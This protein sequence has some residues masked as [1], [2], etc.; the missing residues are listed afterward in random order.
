MFSAAA[1]PS[2]AE[3]STSGAT[4]RRCR[5][6]RGAR[7]KHP[8]CGIRR[9]DGPRRRNHRPLRHLRRRRSSIACKPDVVQPNALADT[10][11]R[12]TARN[13]RRS[14]NQSPVVSQRTRRACSCRLRPGRRSSNHGCSGSALCKNPSPPAPSQKAKRGS[15]KSRGLHTRW[16]P[17]AADCDDR[18]FRPERARAGGRRRWRAT[19]FEF[20]EP[21][22]MFRAVGAWLVSARAFGLDDMPVCG[23]C[24]KS[25]RL[26]LCAAVEGS[27]AR[28]QCADSYAGGFVGRL[29]PGGGQ[30]RRAPA[31][32][33]AGGPWATT[34][35][36]P[37]RN[38]VCEGAIRGTR[39]L[40][41][42]GCN[43]FMTADSE[44]ALSA[45]AE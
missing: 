38:M 16:R 31:S 20:L 44:G 25:L 33:G 17:R 28:R 13:M 7:R 9:T 37:G 23:D 6:H 30:R 12:P 41:D 11:Q 32:G 40:S 43:S 2:F 42:E 14:R 8:A 5:Q 26:E 19:G 39:C 22:A 36:P 3:R 35:C 21:A 18:R 1:I 4:R 34:D 15:K 29:G 10:R 27:T 24:S 45:A